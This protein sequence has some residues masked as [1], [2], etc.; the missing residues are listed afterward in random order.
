MQLTAET[1]TLILSLLVQIVAI[2]W[3]ASRLNT[4]VIQLKEVVEKMETMLADM[5]KRIQ[6]T[7][8][9]VAVLRS[10]VFK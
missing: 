7:T 9:D 2:V 5:D 1:V 8:V 4:S 6:S 3:F 10:A